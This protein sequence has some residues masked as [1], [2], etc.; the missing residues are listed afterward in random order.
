[1]KPLPKLKLIG[2][3]KIFPWK[4]GEYVNLQSI[5]CLEDKV[6]KVV[7]DDTMYVMEISKF[8][9]N[10]PSIFFEGFLTDNKKVGLIA[11]ELTYE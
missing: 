1:M 2:E 9:I 3:N 6:H 5:S 11:F 10:M 7:I 8:G 4:L